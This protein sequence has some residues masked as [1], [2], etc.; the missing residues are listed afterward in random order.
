MTLFNPVTFLKLFRLLS[1][2]II[3]KNVEDKCMKEHISLTSYSDQRSLFTD[4]ELASSCPICGVALSPDILFGELI[5]YDDEEENKVFILNFCPKC[6]ECFISRHVFDVESGE[7]YLFSSSA[8]QKPLRN[9]WGKIISD[10]SPNFVEIYN[11][12]VSAEATGLDQIAGVGYRK[13]LEFLIKDYLISQT[14]DGS[15]IKAIKNKM[16]GKCINEYIDNPQ[17]KIVA[18]RAAWLGND[19]THYEQ[20]FND[21]DISDLKR[22]IRL[23]VHWI[24]LIKETEEAEA[25]QPQK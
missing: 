2:D 19:Q 24:S 13:A 16:L 1:Y 15:T 17:L 11:Q 14:T 7:G 20:R 5:E 10:V 25:I 3:R 18:S 8:P 23:S 22:M 6:D 4:V 21:R 12:S 9:D